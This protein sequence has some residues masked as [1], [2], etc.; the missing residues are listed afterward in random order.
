MLSLDYTYLS[1]NINNYISSSPQFFVDK[2]N[3]Q[4]IIDLASKLCLHETIFRF[5]SSDQFTNWQLEYLTAVDNV[6]EYN[7]HNVNYIYLQNF[8]KLYLSNRFLYDVYVSNEFGS[9]FKNNLINDVNN[10]LSNFE[11]QY[12]ET[13]LNNNYNIFRDI[14]LHDSFRNFIDSFIFSSLIRNIVLDR[15]NYYHVR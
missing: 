3:Y 2:S 11:Y 5:L 7:P 8:V 4:Y 14:F 15:L 9:N 1:T 12:T 6:I 10:I 13:I